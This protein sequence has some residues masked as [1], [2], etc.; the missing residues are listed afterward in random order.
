MQTPSDT[1]KSPEYSKEDRIFNDYKKILRESNNPKDL[2]KFLKDHIKELSEEN[3]DVAVTRVIELQESLLQKYEEKVLEYSTELSHLD[4]DKEKHELP[5]DVQE[6]VEDAKSNGYKITQTNIKID[7]ENI[8]NIAVDYLSDELKDYIKI[9]SDDYSDDYSN[10]SSNYSEKEYLDRLTKDQL[11]KHLDALAKRINQTYIYIEKHKNSPHLLRVKE[12]RKV[13]LDIYLFGSPNNPSSEHYKGYK[14]L[15]NMVYPE[16]R[17]KYTSLES[18]S[19]KWKNTLKGD[20]EKILSKQFSVEMNNYVNE[21]KKNNFMLNEETNK[22]IYKII[23]HN[24][25]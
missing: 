8:N 2:L 18:D 14:I 5:S 22:E 4:I 6:L 3:A 19:I 23:N 9:E 20:D 1:I 17:E 10:K 25:N 16:W 21:L 12:I 24:I 11:D 7:Y 13:Y 15:E